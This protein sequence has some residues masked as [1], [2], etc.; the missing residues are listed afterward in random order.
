MMDRTSDRME[1][2][3]TPPSRPWQLTIFFPPT[4]PT[5]GS[6]IPFANP[7]LLTSE[8]APTALAEYVNEFFYAPLSTRVA[9][10]R[11]SARQQEKVK[12]YRAAKLALQKEL[13]DRLAELRLSPP[14]VR[15]EELAILARAQ[16]P[17]LAA[18]EKMAEELRAEL[19]KGEF[20]Q[21]SVDWNVIRDW[22]LDASR[23]ATVDDALNAQYQVMRAAPFYLRGLLP[24]QRGMLR[25]IAIEFREVSTR[26]RSNGEDSVNP[27]LF[28][29]PA[30]SR[31]RLPAGLP[32]GLADKIAAYEKEKAALKEELRLL[33]YTQ[34]KT[35]LSS[36]R[37]R[38]LEALAEKQWPRIAAL[39]EAAEEI[40]RDLARLPEPPGPPAPPP[41]PAALAARIS[42]YLEERT[43]IQQDILA[44]IGQIKKEFAVQRVVPGKNSGAGGDLRL[45]INPGSQ[46]EER[47]NSLKATLATFNQEMSA[48]QRALRAEEDAIRREFMRAVPDTPGNSQSLETLLNEYAEALL[49]REDWARY[50][51]YQ[52]AMLTPG[53]SPEQRRL[54]YDGA[55]EKLALPLPGWDVTMIRIVR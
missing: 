48:R 10:N 1:R 51:E 30:T 13:R 54:L 26:R 27:P 7:L 16:A 2:D 25:E 40:R 17:R 36:N 42:I 55:V 4:P 46:T 18:L 39:E 45:V 8:R 11:L 21:S 35:Y 23:F 33:V 53:L 14:A 29:S 22:K 34:D 9:E 32:T 28:F 6:P 37:V 12:A 41:L 50:E 5:L 3:Y 31:L 52:T 44:K 19:V 38:A 47:M 49:Q 24:E 15:T 20:F 43:A